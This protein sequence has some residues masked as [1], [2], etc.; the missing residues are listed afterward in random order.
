[1]LYPKN[2]E[3]KLGF[4]Q[5]R[6]WIKQECSG[7][8]G[9]AFVEKMRF[10]NDYDMIDKLVRQ[11]AEMKTIM[12]LHSDEFPS[13]NFIDAVPHLSK[14]AIEG[15]FL[16]EEEFFEIK[17]SLRTI[18]DCLIFFKNQE[19][20]VFP[21]LKELTQAID[22]DSTLLKDI[23][24]VIDQRGKLRDDASPEL[25][26]IRRQIIAEQANLRKKLESILKQS[27]N[28]GYTSDDASATIRNGR[29]VI[30]VAAEHKR[31][32]K[33]FIQDESATGQTIYL[34]PVEIF[35]LNNEI[36]ELG[37]REKR[38]IIRILTHL[39]DRLRPHVPNL[40][41]AYTFLGLIDFIRAKAKFALRTQANLPIFSKKTILIWENTRHP[42]LYLSFQKQG[43]S[44][45]P[46]SI[47]LEEKQRILVISG[48]NAGGKSIA[49]KTVGL[50][51]YMFQCG[52]LVCMDDHS[53]IGLFRDIFIDIGDEQSL[54]NDLSTYSSHLTNMKYFL[55]H[56]DKN[57]L[58]LID[59][60]GTGTEPGMGGA[61]AETILDALQQ[62]KAFGVLNTHYGNLKAYA[63]RT[64]GVAN[65]AMRFDA[66]HLEPLYQL[67]I[68][69][70]GSS[71][72]FEIAQKIGLPR[73]IVTKSKQ[74][75]GTTQ[76]DF[77]KMLRELETEKQKFAEQNRELQTKEKTLNETL[78][79]YN[80]LKNELE[81]GRKQLLNKAKE[82]ARRLVKDANQKIETTIREI[83][84]VKAEKDL[85]KML[86]QDLADFE[87][88]LKPE[89]VVVEL[90]P[91][92]EIKVIGGTIEEGDLVRIKGQNTVGEV[93]SIKG[94][95]AEIRIGEL[96][97]NVKINRLEKIS[98]KEYRQQTV[99][100]QPRMQGIDINEKMANFSTQLDL[101]GKRGEEALT[102]V[103]AWIDQG[104]ML[105]SSE[106]R[107]V[108]GKGDG[109]LRN[110][111]RNHLRRYREI[112]SMNDEHADR[113]GSGVTIIKMK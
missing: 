58:F 96:K 112:A 101:R 51:Q 98:R 77:D 5:I 109:I 69:R 106:L 81:T 2:L 17:L 38:E 75:V 111:I 6:E 30:P 95:D 50:T 14:A 88:K 102:E 32:I 86:R 107:I 54:E 74:K 33:G 64:E 15:M 18:Y 40:K 10:S 67:E 39:T 9:K 43:K 26:T 8:L 11:T 3:Q 19:E 76:V 24:R 48:P 59:E 91:A 65:A 36:T 46:L 25:Q 23:D 97:S 29:M 103:D 57:T 4:D 113:G 12:L 53:Q 22:I 100:N 60:F 84:E 80:A 44:V 31:K 83:R 20:N 45:I 47:K 104:I 37:Y 99:E 61:I 27:I 105:G 49:L 42:L 79:K 89:D 78:T 16:T 82:D 110:L 35:D 13:S 7:T 1:M 94:K 70:P 87:K 34:E 56:A 68:G 92:P 93:L 55:Q 108:H 62:K 90:E 73:E 41:K 63:N 28:Q 52:L 21:Q 66:E 71:F 85:T 72:A